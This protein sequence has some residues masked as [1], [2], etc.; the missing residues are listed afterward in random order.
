MKLSELIR[1]YGDE[2]VKFQNL[3][4]SID[5]IDYTAKKGTKITF[6]TEAS[7]EPMRGTRELGLVVWF[8]RKAL[9]AVMD[10]DMAA[11]NGG[12]SQ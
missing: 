12:P 5:S 2:R 10:A 3:D 4:G 8:D 11:L 1:L 6:R 7:I 9:K